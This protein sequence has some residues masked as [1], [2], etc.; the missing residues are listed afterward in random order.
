MS[1]QS[2]N[3]KD[4]HNKGGLLALLGSIGFVF[5]FFFYIVYINSGVDLAENVTDPAVPGEIQFDLASVE[6]AWISSDDIVKAGAKL[7]KQ[8]CA[9][10]HGANGDLVGGIANA[11]NLVVGQ[12]KMGGSIGHYKVLQDG[13]AGTQ[14]VSFKAQL[15][16][17]ERWALVHFIESI[18][19][20]KSQDKPEDV[21]AFALTAD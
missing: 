7:Y 19:K 17:K 11:R 4:F 14:M 5:V 8:N 18:T 15:N 3:Q 9:L 20:N 13:I 10:C 2:S 6:K 16:A 21:E 12:W 1:E